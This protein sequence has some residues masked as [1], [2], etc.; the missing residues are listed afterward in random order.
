MSV[1]KF[2]LQSPS[3]LQQILM[4][5]HLGSLRYTLQAERNYLI[6][7]IIRLQIKTK[8]LWHLHMAFKIG[9]TWGLILIQFWNIK[10]GWFSLVL[11]HLGS[12]GSKGHIFGIVLN[13]PGLYLQLWHFVWV[14]SI[15]LGMMPLETWMWSKQNTTV[16]HT[17]RHGFT[18]YTK[19]I[20]ALFSLRQLGALWYLWD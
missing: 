8:M 19:Y 18:L 14:R 1:R 6:S 10:T 9:I 2:T 13:K 5:Q 20:L 16:K 12:K 3:K 7:F 11:F 4:C 15:K 17:G